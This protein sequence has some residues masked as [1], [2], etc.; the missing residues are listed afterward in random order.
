MM[1]FFKALMD[2]TFQMH[3]SGLVIVAMLC[4]DALGQVRLDCVMI[5]RIS[6][7]IPLMSWKILILLGN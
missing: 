2:A 4:D 6:F 7:G 1:P 5:P 3:L